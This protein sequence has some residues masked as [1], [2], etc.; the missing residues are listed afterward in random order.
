MALLSCEFYPCSSCDEVVGIEWAAKSDLLLRR[1]LISRTIAS[2]KL[3]AQLERDHAG[4]AIT[5]QT[6]AEQTSRWR[7]RVSKRSETGLRG[8]LPRNAGQHHARKCEIRVI[9]YVEELR[10]ESQFHTLGQ[11]E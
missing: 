10:V 11:G 5:A 8:G 7:G 2:L 4:R 6:N 3:Q 9:E 1:T